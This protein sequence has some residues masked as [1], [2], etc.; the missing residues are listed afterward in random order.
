[1]SNIY[2][3]EDDRDLQE[4]IKIL[5]KKNGYTVWPFGNSKHFLESLKSEIPDLVIMD[6][7]LADE[8][9]IALYKTIKS[10]KNTHSVPVMLM[11]GDHIE[12][13]IFKNCLADGFIGKPFNI[14]D[15]LSK[16][17]SLISG[18]S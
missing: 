18:A 3:L 16:I 4:M 13:E 17:E 14:K 8:S 12:P 1:M 5:L 15:F 6:V 7:N 10:D 9:G 11:S 2:V